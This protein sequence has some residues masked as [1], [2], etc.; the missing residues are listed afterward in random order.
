MEEASLE[1]REPPY[2]RY[3]SRG[4]MVTCGKVAT[5]IHTAYRIHVVLCIIFI[6]ADEGK[7]QLVQ[8]NHIQGE[9]AQIKLSGFHI[10]IL[11][12]GFF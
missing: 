6:S 4:Q 12:K 10:T 7:A 2:W 3:S 8:G 9:Q 5:Q 11:S 1:G